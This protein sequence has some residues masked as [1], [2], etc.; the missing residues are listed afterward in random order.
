MRYNYTAVV[1]ASFLDIANMSWSSSN[2]LR[3]PSKGDKTHSRLKLPTFAGI[4]KKGSL[5]Y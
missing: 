1:K 2:I 5:P 4:E 3:L